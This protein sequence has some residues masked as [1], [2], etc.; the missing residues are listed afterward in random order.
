M[1]EVSDGGKQATAPEGGAVFDAHA[2]LSEGSSQVVRTKSWKTHGYVIPDIE[3][4]SGFFVDAGD[5]ERCIVAADT[6]QIHHFP[7]VTLKDGRSYSASVI[8][9]NDRNEMTY[10][11]VYGVP[12]PA[13]TCKGVKLSQTDNSFT[14][15]QAVFLV[16]YPRSSGGAQKTLTGEVVPVGVK[17]HGFYTGMFSTPKVLDVGV[18][19]IPGAEPGTSGAPIFDD[20]GEVIAVV[21]GGSPQYTSGKPIAGIREDIQ[22]LPE[23]GSR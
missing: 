2:L 11:E 17:Q 18:F 3:R 9:A 5:R 19:R 10:L 21:A 15:P 22:G 13:T 8:K 6:H 14:T 20:Q 7:S 23:K 4:G 12:E 16:G 1:G